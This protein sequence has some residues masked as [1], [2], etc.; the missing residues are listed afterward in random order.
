MQPRTVVCL[1]VAFVGYGVFLHAARAGGHG[2]G[3]DQPA[4]PMFPA[5]PAAPPVP[6]VPAEPVVPG[7]GAGEYRGN[8]STHYDGPV[9]D[10]GDLRIRLH[11][12][13]A[14]MEQEERTISKAEARVL[15]VRETRNGGVQV[16]GWDHDVYSVTAC[17]AAVGPN[18]EAQRL[19]SQIKLSV[20]GGEVSVS[21]PVEQDDWA[22]FLLIR[23]PK[24]AD[25]EL[26]THNG[27]A[28]FHGVDGKIT[29]RALNGPL[30]VKDC[31][32]EGDIAAVNGPISF[33]GTNGKLRLHTENGPISVALDRTSWNGA[34]LVAEAVNGP[35]TL[36]LPS[37]F[38]SSF[39]VESNEHT[40]V[41]CQASICSEVRR[42]W[43]DQHRRMEYGSGEPVIRLSTQNGPISVL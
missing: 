33:S 43:D 26:S 10:C 4:A 21:G 41:S 3:Q 27:P 32:G 36:R 1:V 6:A 25:I 14:T 37:G 34:G 15:H 35:L 29:A 9:S 23:T 30:T 40:P 12:E 39:L 31:S 16:Q 19:L 5:A 20:Q 24:A 17:K 28:S 7:S 42:T 8:G 11:N 2:G 38:Q 13:K 18:G 22:V